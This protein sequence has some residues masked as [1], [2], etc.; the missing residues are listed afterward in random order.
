MCKRT[1]DPML[2]SNDYS[3]K[4]AVTGA[5]GF[6]GQHLLKACITKGYV[7]YAIVRTTTN[8][9]DIVNLPINIIKIDYTSIETI[10]E[11]IKSSQPHLSFDYFIH[12]AGQI[13]AY[14]QKEYVD[15]NVKLT[16][17]LLEA[18]GKKKLL[19]P[20]GKFI[21]VSSYAAH[22]PSSTCYPVSY[23]G[24]SKKMAE[25]AVISSGLPYMIVRPTA[26]YGSGTL[27]FLPLFQAI[28]KGIY[29]LI[30]NRKQKVT[31]IHAKDL[32]EII[33]TNM[34]NNQQIFHV[35]DGN[36]YTHQQIKKIVENILNKK[37]IT[38]WFPKPIVISILLLMDIWNKW[39]KQKASMTK[40]RFL[41][42]SSDWDLI[43]NKKLNHIN[44]PIS[45]SL[46][47][48]MKEAHTYYKKHGMI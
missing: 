12:N 4:V 34:K 17:L 33:V 44:A 48:G 31:M 2:Q 37:S 8:I 30:T 1:T 18:L 32:A 28:K 36:V 45:Y 25:K 29:P 21:Y 9:K 40:E 5:N 41:E 19:Q 38:I 7:T 43:K 35:C 22:G 11:S 3:L 24:K 39:T 16:V 14:R 26:V 27:A 42:I 6:I 20:Q 46:K 23:Y 47:K 10:I 13:T 15:S